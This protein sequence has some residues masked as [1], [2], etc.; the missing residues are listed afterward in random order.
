MAISSLVGSS[1]WTAA[2]VTVCAVSQFVVAN[3]S[4]LCSPVAGAV[5]TVTA[6]VSALVTVTVTVPVGSAASFTE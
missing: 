4:A 2:R 5:S 3:E 6:A 1:S